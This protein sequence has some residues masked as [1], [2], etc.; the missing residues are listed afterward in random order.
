MSRR[1]GSRFSRRRIATGGGGAPAPVTPLTILGSLAWWVR[2]DLGIT[3]GT[4]VA[5][6]ADQSGNGADFVQVTGANQPALTVA[7][8]NGRDA[9]TGDGVNDR[10]AATLA[11]AAP[12]TQPFYICLLMR[13][14]AWSLN[15]QI[16][17]DGA[18]VLHMSATTPNLRTNNAI[19]STE[20]AAATVGSF[21]LV[22]MYFS[23][24]VAD[25]LRIGATAVTGVNTGNSAGTGSINLFGNSAGS[26]CA[27]S[28]IC[29]GL[30]F[31]GTPTGTGGL[32]GG[33]QRAQL[34]QYFSDRYGESVL[35]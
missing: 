3:L 35:A 23:N 31:L 21:K 30:M 25:Y 9:V 14:N 29:E 34:A 17:N 20:N 26:T 10:L 6:W 1:P 4:G 11:R 13:Q 5:A 24:S 33:G 7:A 32:T 19:N 15:R 12:G 16:Y 2:A 8:I 18:T 28:A 27:S 22:E